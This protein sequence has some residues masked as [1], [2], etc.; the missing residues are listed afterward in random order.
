MI[1]QANQQVRGG[2]NWTFP[3]APSFKYYVI[4][5]GGRQVVKAFGDLDDKRVGFIIWEN[6][7]T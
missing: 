4:G 3:R 6:L 7:M 1:S 5:L 2:Q